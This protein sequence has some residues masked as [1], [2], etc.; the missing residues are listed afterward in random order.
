MSKPPRKARI[1]LISMPWQ[2]PFSPSIQLGA[3]TAYV[4]RERPDVE[5]HTYEL[6]LELADAIG[7]H[8]AKRISV[9]W[10]G[11]ALFAYLL[12]PTRAHSI[13]GYLEGSRKDD[14]AFQ[15]LDFS[16]LMERLRVS[17]LRRLDEIDWT[18]YQMVGLSV[19]FSQTMP[20]L[21][22]AREI[23]RRAPDVPIVFGGPSCTNLIGKSLLETF[24]FIDYVVN[25]EGERPLVNLLS[26][27]EQ[28][29]R[30]ARV[31][32][33]AVVHRSSEPGAFGAIDQA[34]D[35]AALPA[36]NFDGYFQT[37]SRTT[38]PAE[39]RGRL[40]VPVETSRGC[41]WDR[42]HVDPMLSCTFCNLNLQWKAYREKPVAQSL[43]ELKQL[44][45]KYECPD[46]TVVDN[47]LR[48]KA[49]D[50]FIT[51]LKELGMGLDLWMEA[52][53]SVRPAQIRQLSEA[54]GRV[55]Q[56]GVE[57]LSSSVLEKMVKG[58]TALQNLQAM[59]FC[60]QYGVQNTAN[61]ITDYPGMDERDVLETLQNIEF[62]RAYRPLSTTE[63]SLVY[64]APAYK[65]PE[66]F[67]IQNI[68]NYHMYQLLLPPELNERLFLTEKSFDSDSLTQL[69][70]LW[71][72]V[73]AA[74]VAW[75]EHY[76]RMRP[77]VEGNL[78]L[79]LQ[80]GGQY[81]KI[82]DFRAKE[83]RFYWL[84][85]WERDLY[86][87]CDTIIALK[88]LS[89]LFPELDAAR[90]EAC[91]QRWHAQRLV[92]IERGKVLA[93]AVPWGPVSAHRAAAPARKQPAMA[94]LAAAA[95]AH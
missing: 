32:V 13:A 29:P 86:L 80:E 2:D 42:S 48:H 1:A 10:I 73:K 43:E 14:P 59:K 7:I 64:Q 85:G 40:R 17:L 33:R 28:A 6:F 68:R 39:T 94:P 27:L 19:V 79:S 71:A 51:G 26:A 25:G 93:L 50:E 53:A 23:K 9:S 44:A 66:R 91:L 61:L 72:R 21:L 35:M 3:L 34:P 87:A 82:R 36:P 90:L 22:A 78:L 92:F 70:P 65:A 24:D 4:N 18:Q 47:I 63:F 12:F 81:L 5:V 74:V 41:W 77:M 60:E 11:E 31:N 45:L 62:A 83:P 95:E 20:S 84:R 30:G 52:R 89:L 57:A 58:T 56:F 76:E 67:G 75:K 55:I 37:L 38:N 49:A 46:F 69:K 8:L 16:Q 54:G 88:E 15:G